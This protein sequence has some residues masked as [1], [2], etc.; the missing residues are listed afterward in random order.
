M[1][2]RISSANAHRVQIAIIAGLL[3]VI[4]VLVLVASL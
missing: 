3:L 4:A 1:K 2:K